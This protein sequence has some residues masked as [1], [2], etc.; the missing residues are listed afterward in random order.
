MRPA[1][2][3]DLPPA[4]QSLEEVGVV[5]NRDQWLG[6]AENAERS[7]MPVTAR[8]VKPAC[9][10]LHAGAADRTVW[11]LPSLRTFLLS[12]RCPGCPAVRSRA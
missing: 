2:H 11:S 6:F 12:E 1:P 10:G 9:M 8:C 3:T 7:G 5:I 4:L